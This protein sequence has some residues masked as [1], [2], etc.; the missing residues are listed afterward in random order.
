MS[1]FQIVVL[2]VVGRGRV[3]G[4]VVH[5]TRHPEGA[6]R[7]SGPNHDNPGPTARCSSLTDPEHRL[8]RSQDDGVALHHTEGN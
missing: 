8:W 2:G 3:D 4:H 1:D 6:K 5:P 7:S